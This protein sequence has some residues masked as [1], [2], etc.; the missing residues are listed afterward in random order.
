MAKSKKDLPDR[1]T[2]VRITSEDKALLDEIVAMEERLH[3]VILHRA[4]RAYAA[5]RYPEKYSE[6]T[7]SDHPQ[8]PRQELPKDD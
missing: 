5:S 8:S 7:L 3:G 6:L 1:G 4:L 2:T